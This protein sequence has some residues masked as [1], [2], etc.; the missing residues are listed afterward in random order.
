MNSD[1]SFPP[2]SFM[3]NAIV[4]LIAWLVAVPIAG[5]LFDSLFGP[6]ELEALAY[7]GITLTGLILFFLIFIPLVRSR[8]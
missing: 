8:R 3:G 4:T 6:E 1:K 5:F 2:S 7:I